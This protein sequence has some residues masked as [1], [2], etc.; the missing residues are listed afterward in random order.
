MKYVLLQYVTKAEF[1]SNVRKPHWS[2]EEDQ[3]STL[4]AMIL[5]EQTW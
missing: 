1:F 4:Y 3:K 5:N 2:K